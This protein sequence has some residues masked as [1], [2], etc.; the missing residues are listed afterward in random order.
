GDYAKERNIPLGAF[1]TGIVILRARTCRLPSEARLRPCLSP[2]STPGSTSTSTRI[3]TDIN[4]ELCNDRDLAVAHP[5]V[6]TA[7]SIASSVPA[8]TLFQLWRRFF[9]PPREHLSTA[10]MPFLIQ[11][12]RFV[13]RRQ[14]GNFSTRVTVSAPPPAP[15]LPVLPPV[16]PAQS[17][18]GSDHSKKNKRQH[19]RPLKAPPT[20]PSLP[21]LSH[22][23]PAVSGHHRRHTSL[24]MLAKLALQQSARNPTQDADKHTAGLQV[25]ATACR[26]TPKK[27]K[28]SLV[29]PVKKTLATSAAPPVSQESE[30][31]TET[32]VSSVRRKP[33]VRR[34]TN[35]SKKHTKKRRVQVVVQHEDTASESSEWSDEDV[36]L[37]RRDQPSRSKRQAAFVASS[38]I[39]SASRGVVVGRK[40]IR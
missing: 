19:S 32:Q 6:W 25:L 4:D 24:D 8:N 14:E 23:M 11:V 7:L 22:S 21:I 12:A 5:S 9:I 13:A 3:A 28:L 15:S 17:K 31:E 37:F 10:R 38:R 35:S 39:T 30:V 40:R 29:T 33:S 1:F 2:L 18:N 27:A 16:A 26:D 20:P 36:V 34:S